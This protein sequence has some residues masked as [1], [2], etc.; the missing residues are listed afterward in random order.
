M[1]KM[2]DDMHR[3]PGPNEALHPTVSCVGSD[4]ILKGVDSPT[5]LSRMTFELFMLIL[6]LAHGMFVQGSDKRSDRLDFATNGSFSLILH[7]YLAQDRA[8]TQHG[9]CRCSTR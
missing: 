4:D 5:A 2:E 6:M 1:A 3:F 7:T 9:A 8:Y